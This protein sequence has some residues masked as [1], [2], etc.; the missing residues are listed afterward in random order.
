ME[1]AW[2]KGGRRGGEEEGPFFFE[3]FVDVEEGEDACEVGWLVQG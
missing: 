2:G 3:G 1:F